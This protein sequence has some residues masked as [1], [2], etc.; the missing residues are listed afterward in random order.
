MSI[1]KN[2]KVSAEKGEKLLGIL[3]DPDRFS[4]V[5]ELMLLIDALKEN[6]PNYLFV[7]GSLINNDFF[8]VTILTLKKHLTVPVIIFPGNNQQLST[9]A[10]GVLLLS[11]ISGRNPEYLIGQHV[12][13]SFM[14]KRSGLEILSTGYVLVS[15]GAPTSAQYIS[16]TSPIPF[17]KD[18]IA[19]A[20]ALA[21][22]QLGLS[23]FY[24]DG[25]SGA[26]SPISSSMIK[27]VRTTITSP[28]IVGGGIKNKSEIESAWNA[29]AD[30]VI[31]GTAFEKNP[32][33]VSELR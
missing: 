13:T 31:V 19:A 20:T 11:L 29:G 16:N 33:I 28:L 15:C 23:L 14:L 6:Q 22:E 27:K 18:G 7:G 3:I 26:D 12:N 30:L 32:S 9:N 10:D 8:E 17:A 5:E 4:T 24:L 21:G 25:G 1:L 2:I